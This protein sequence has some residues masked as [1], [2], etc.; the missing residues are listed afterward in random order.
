MRVGA[1]SSP[2]A[3]FVFPLLSVFTAF[4]L[5]TIFPVWFGFGCVYFVTMVGFVPNRSYEIN[6]YNNSNLFYSS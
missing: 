4:F 5:P 3:D 1:R 2:N 6:S